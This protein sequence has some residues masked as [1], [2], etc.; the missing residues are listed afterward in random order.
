MR[1]TQWLPAIFQ[2]SPVSAGRQVETGPG[3]VSK[4]WEQN[5]S[6]YLYICLFMYSCLGPGLGKER[7]SGEK[8][9][10]ERERQRERDLSVVLLFLSS[11]PRAASPERLSSKRIA[12]PT[13]AAMPCQSVTA[14]P[15]GQCNGHDMS[16]VIATASGQA[17]GSCFWPSLA[18]A[19]GQT[20]P[21]HRQAK[22]EPGRPHAVNTIIIL[23]FPLR[24]IAETCSPVS[25]QSVP[26]G[27]GASN[28]QISTNFKEQQRSKLMFVFK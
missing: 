16:M 28:L 8:R 13:S 17:W 3:I 14:K 4:T 5:A 22:A 6:F 19:H 25:T 21:N 18:H 7:E 10:R 24:L 27:L 20:K 23:I 1:P 2:A 12:R 9:E 15:A 26:L 11:L